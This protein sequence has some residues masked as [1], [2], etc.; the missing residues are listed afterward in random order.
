MLTHSNYYLKIDKSPFVE[1]EKDHYQSRAAQ[2]QNQGIEDVNDIIIAP[3][4]VNI[5]V[6]VTQ[7]KSY[8]FQASGH[9]N[10]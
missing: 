3:E 5:S 6:L 1:R 7:R 10:P 2:V 4:L 9:R 8:S